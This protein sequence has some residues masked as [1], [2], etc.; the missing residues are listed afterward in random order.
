MSRH[1]SEACQLTWKRCQAVCARSDKDKWNLAAYLFY[2]VPSSYVCLF[3]SPVSW[4][5]DTDLLQHQVK[6]YKCGIWEDTEKGWGRILTETE[7]MQKISKYRHWLARGFKRAQINTYETNLHWTQTLGPSKSDLVLLR[8]AG[9]I[10]GL[11]IK[12]LML[13]S[14]IH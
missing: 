5:I 8:L 11:S 10:Q 4:K 9:P 3:V 2:L 6:T 1:S 12:S 7:H 14:T 13:P